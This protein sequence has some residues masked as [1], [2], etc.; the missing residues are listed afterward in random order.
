MS[1][2]TNELIS[3]RSNMMRFASLLLRDKHVVEDVVQETMLAAI[4][5]Q[6]GFKNQSSMK[7]WV[8]SILRNKAIDVLRRRGRELCMTDFALETD[9]HLDEALFNQAGHW[10]Q[11]ARPTGWCDPEQSLEQTQFWVVLETCLQRLPEQ[12]ASVFILREFLGLEVNEICK[13]MCIS[14]SNCWTILHRARSSLRLCLDQLW[15]NP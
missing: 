10:E 13:K 1:I 5:H 3:L 14:S 2:D 9:D 6:H 15:F 7:T 12:T 8:F 4:E 11:S